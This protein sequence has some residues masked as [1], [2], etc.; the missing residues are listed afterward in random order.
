[1]AWKLQHLERESKGLNAAKYSRQRSEAGRSGRRTPW[2]GRSNT[3]KESQASASVGREKFPLDR[4]VSAGGRRAACAGRPGPRLCPRRAGSPGPH[5]RPCQRRWALP[6]RAGTGTSTGCAAAA[7]MA[8]PVLLLLLLLWPD[9]TSPGPPPA[10]AVAGQEH[11][12]AAPLLP[13]W[14]SPVPPPCNCDL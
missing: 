11:G 13:S 7:A 10:C 12:C 6:G 4:P 2:V 3:S 9:R 14:A 8:G 5:P 1:M